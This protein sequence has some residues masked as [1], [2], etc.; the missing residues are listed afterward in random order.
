M[1]L[2]SYRCNSCGNR[3]E[4]YLKIAECRDAQEC[5]ICSHELEK[6]IDSARISVDY[7]GYTCPISGKWIEGKK[8]H[9]ENLAKYGKR[10]LEKGE[11]QECRKAKA[12]EEEEFEKKIDE[13][14]EKQLAQLSTQQ[15]EVLAKEVLSSDI[16]IDRG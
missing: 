5:K 1:P 7:A 3:E 8:A 4:K 16:S 2:Y 9:K 11:L 14:V 6:L 12:R 10:V 15:M 13:G